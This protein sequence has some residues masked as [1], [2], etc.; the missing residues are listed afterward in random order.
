MR[1]QFIF[2]R[3]LQRPADRDDHFFGVR[4]RCIKSYET[5]E[6]GD[7]QGDRHLLRSGRG[8]EDV[9]SAPTYDQRTTQAQ[10]P[11]W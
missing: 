1:V 6:A 5:E 8:M 3:L 2:D 11:S 4:F 7:S 10:K 9:V